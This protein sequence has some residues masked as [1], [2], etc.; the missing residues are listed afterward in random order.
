MKT[1]PLSKSIFRALGVRLTDTDPELYLHEY[2]LWNGSTR[3]IVGARDLT[4][5]RRDADTGYRTAD[6]AISMA[7]AEL[8]MLGW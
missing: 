3:F 6:A 2:C 8:K 5:V 7:A 1:Y 4:D